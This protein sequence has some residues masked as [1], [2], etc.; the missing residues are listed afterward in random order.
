MNRFFNYLIDKTS[1][2]KTISE[3]LKVLGYSRHVLTHL[4]KTERGILVNGEW[5]YVNRHLQSGDRLQ[6]HLIEENSSEKIIPVPMELKIIYEDEDILVL[7]KPAD[8]PIHPSLNNYKN[9]LANGVAHYFQEQGKSY[10]FR[11]VNRLDRDTTGLTILAKNL[12]GSSILSSMVSKRE[13]HRSYLAIVSG[14]LPDSGVIRAPIGRVPGSTIERQVDFEHGEY[15]ATHYTCL[16]KNE[17]HT[18]AA[19]TL[20]T[21]RTHQIRVHMKYIGAPLIGDYIYNPDYRHIKR[22][23]LHS[24]RL[25]FMH[26]ITKQPLSFQ[27][28]LPI[29]MRLF[30]FE[31]SNP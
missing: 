17:N 16:A 7:D 1:D 9:S 22:Q 13:I 6:I 20:E 29:D 18:L 3:Y 5:A 10:I 4:K 23:A 25:D 12:L 8:T 14:T 24:H 15:A 2:G 26:P 21:G 11:C 19:L 27:S 30:G 28:A 31:T